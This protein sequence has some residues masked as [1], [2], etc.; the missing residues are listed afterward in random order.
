V[1]K[2][3]NKTYM[4]DKTIG[5]FFFVLVWA[6]ETRAQKAPVQVPND[7]KNI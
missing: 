5:D 3:I 2:K 6:L 7:E 1:T 4:A